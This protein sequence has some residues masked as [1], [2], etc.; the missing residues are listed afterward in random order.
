MN[1]RLNRWSFGTEFECISSR[2][3]NDQLATSSFRQGSHAMSKVRSFLAGNG[4]FL[5]PLYILQA[6]VSLRHF[7]GSKIEE[8]ELQRF[9]VLFFVYDFSKDLVVRG[10]FFCVYV[11]SFV[12]KRKYC[13]KF[14]IYTYTFSTYIFVSFSI[15]VCL[16]VCMWLSACLFASLSVYPS[17]YPGDLSTELSLASR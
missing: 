5:V 1:I 15:S 6:L 11:T 10:L 8:V 13:V 12:V 2:G 4:H 16:S 17:I 14:F 3:E 9:L 7:M